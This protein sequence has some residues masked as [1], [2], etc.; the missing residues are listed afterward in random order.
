MFWWVEKGKTGRRAGTSGSVCESFDSI[1][2]F[3]LGGCGRTLP[4]VFST[5]VIRR[6]GGP[7]L[8]FGVAISLELNAVV[9]GTSLKNWLIDRFFELLPFRFLWLFVFV[10]KGVVGA[11][12]VDAILEVGGVVGDVMLSFV[13]GVFSFPTDVFE[14]PGV[15]V[16]VF[17]PKGVK[18]D[19]SI[20]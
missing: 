8:L 14:M 6:G 15:S 16:G 18:R 19:G 9:L 10:V 4:G 12:P 1:L 5:L 7:G 3:R 13:L 2:L 17:L 11:T 20:A